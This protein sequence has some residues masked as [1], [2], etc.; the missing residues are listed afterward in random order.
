[1][2]HGQRSDAYR[3]SLSALLIS[4]MLVLG[5]VESLVPTGI[6]GV[7]I[8]LSNGVLIFAVYMLGIPSAYILMTLK[9]VL[10]GLLFSGVSGMIYA[11]AGGLASVTLMS[12]LSKCKKLSPVPVS[13]AGGVCH[14][15]GQVAVAVTILSPSPKMLY[16]LGILVLV[17]LVCGLATGLAANSVMGHLRAVRWQ[18]GQ[19]PEKSKKDLVLIAVAAALVMGG[20]AFAYRHMEQSKP[21]AP[22][23]TDEKSPLLSPDALPFSVP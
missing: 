2:S 16:Y 20:L 15:L 22:V 17:G 12:L 14:N 1:M 8:G 21:V 13:M 10:S 9:V 7:K 6:P 18:G 11:F 19:R 3:L 5:Y 23:E 4:L